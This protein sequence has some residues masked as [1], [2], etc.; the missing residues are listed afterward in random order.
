MTFSIA[1]LLCE[2]T[3]TVARA[4]LG[5][6]LVHE[7][8]DGRTSGRIVETEAYVQGDPASHS[9]RGRTR[10][11][12]S[13]FERAGVIYVYKV[14]MQHCINLVTGPEEQGDAVLIRALEPLEGLELMRHRRGDKPDHQLCAGPGKLTQA[15]GIDRSHDGLHVLTGP[16]FIQEGEPIADEAVAADG[17]IGIREGLDLPWRFCV[18]SSRSLSRRPR[19]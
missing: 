6:V 18:R 7:S 9:T 2:D 15:M 14:H 16:I 10:R 13:M 12:R 17:R 19:A 4:L 1:E 5:R 8:T 3:L 11:N